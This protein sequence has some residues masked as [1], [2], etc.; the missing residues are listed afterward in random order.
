MS[1]GA[2]L[3]AIV[4]LLVGAVC[5]AADGALLAGSLSANAS[6]GAELPTGGFRDWTHRALSTARLIAHLTAGAAAAV[7]FDLAGRP[8]VAAVVLAIAAAIVIVF[9]GEV[10][11]RAFGDAIGQPVIVALRPAVAAIEWLVGPLVGAGAAI[12]RA[13]RRLMPPAEPTEA[14]RDASAEQFSRVVLAEAAVPVDQRAMLHRAFDLGDT[15]VQEVMVP[16]VDIVGIERDTPWSEVLDRVF[17]SRHA[18][19]PVYE[20]TL[21]QVTGAL[22]AKDLLPAVVAHEEPAGGWQT[23]LRPVAFIPESKTIDAQLHDFKASRS[24]IAIVVDEYGGTAGL[25]TIEDI[26]EELVGE[27]RDEYDREEPAIQAEEGRRFW[28]SGRVTLDDLSE[29]LNHHFEGDE[30]TTVGGLIYQLLGRVPR[31]GE[32]LTLNGFRIVVERVVRRRVDRVYFERHEELAE[33][34]P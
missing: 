11:P 16:R 25:V 1:P 5:A 13:L 30:V 31:A 12:D 20:E 18:R 33:N 7:G 24:H 29:A 22:F 21:D 9:L 32:E 10:A 2:L 15:E 27:I 4:A 17:S 34:R 19:L 8:T 28:V 14:E 26:L 23:L 6:R 3:L